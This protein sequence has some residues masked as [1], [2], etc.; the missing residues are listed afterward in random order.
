MPVVLDQHIGLG[1]EP[2]ENVLGARIFQVE[3]DAALVAVHHHEGHRL[4]VDIR[5]PHA[6]RVVATRDFLDLHDVRTHVGQHQAADRAC[7]DVAEIENAH[8]FERALTGCLTQ[9]RF[10]FSSYG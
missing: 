10:P 5:R 1:D 8:P 7:H 4:A 9:G 2:L 3:R 6:A